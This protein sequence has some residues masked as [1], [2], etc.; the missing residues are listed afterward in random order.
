MYICVYMYIYTY[1]YKC[2]CLFCQE[3]LCH[4]FLFDICIRLKTYKTA[5]V[6]KRDVAPHKN[7]IRPNT[8]VL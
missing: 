3:W 8:R 4:M 2:R 7:D 5:I 6:D 1:K